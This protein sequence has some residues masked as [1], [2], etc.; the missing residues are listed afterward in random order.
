MKRTIFIPIGGADTSA[1]HMAGGNDKKNVAGC[2]KSRSDVLEGPDFR[3]L[4]KTKRS[5]SGERRDE[6]C[7]TMPTTDVGT[8]QK[9]LAKTLKE[10]ARRLRNQKNFPEA[11][12]TLEQ[13]LPLENGH[14]LME[15][16][17]ELG[18][19]C[20][21]IGDMD[22]SME[23]HNTALKMYLDRSSAEA[24]RSACFASLAIVNLRHIA[25]MYLQFN[26]CQE[27]LVCYTFVYKIQQDSQDTP[28]QDVAS[29]LSCCG[30]MYYFMGNFPEALRFYQGELCVR[31]QHHNGCMEKGDVAVALNSIGIVYFQLDYFDEARQSFLSC[32]QIRQRLLGEGCGIDGK[33]VHACSNS[34]SAC[35]PHCSCYDLAMVYFNLAAIA[36]KQGNDDEACRLYRQSMELKKAVIGSKHPELAADYQFL[37]QLFLDNGDIETAVEYYREAYKVIQLL[38]SCD[39]QSFSTSNELVQSAGQK[40]LVI[41][42]NIQL[43]DANVEGM[44]KSFAEAA[45]IVDSAA[46]GNSFMDQVRVFGYHLYSIRCMHPPC[47]AEA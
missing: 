5:G 47:A 46:S 10:T 43:L 22:S 30:L 11:R 17:T 45:R 8:S 44:M 2:P 20:F 12:N 39:G 37:G 14:A 34:T 26:R 29:T 25:A 42:G 13:L 33:G 27:A 15:S 32:L 1:I 41:I 7:T 35:D 38:G 28:L 36:M 23:Y 4:K 40:L 19:I 21:E 3:P 31:L 18:S 9:E 16:L 6:Q 24:E